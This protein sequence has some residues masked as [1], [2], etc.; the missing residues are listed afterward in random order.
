MLY[1][2]EVIR[3]KV[4]VRVGNPALLVLQKIFFGEYFEPHKLV[5]LQGKGVHE[6]DWGSF[7]GD[8]LK[9]LHLGKSKFI[10]EEEVNGKTTLFY[11]LHSVDPAKTMS[12]K[13]EEVWIEK[14]TYFPIKYIH[15]D[16]SGQVI[17]RSV[18][19]NLVFNTDLQVDIFKKFKTDSHQRAL[20]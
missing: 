6:S 5:D 7:I 11:R 8:H 2:P 14:K 10:G 15:Y 9:L 16:A 12:I 13:I 3:D 19:N 4:R 20:D 1:N 17:R 18:F